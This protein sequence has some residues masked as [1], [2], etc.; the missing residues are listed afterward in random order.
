MEDGRI[1]ERG[2]HAELLTANGAYAELYN[3]QFEEGAGADA[4]RTAVEEDQPIRS[5]K[6]SRLPAIERRFSP[7]ADAWYERSSWLAL[8]APLSWLYGSVAK[9]RR[10]SY[11]TGR[12]TPWRASVPVIVVGNI[13]AGGTGK[14]P[15]VIWLAK[16]LKAMGFNPGIVSRGH[17]GSET[18]RPVSV[19]ADSSADAVGDE[20]PLLAARTGLPVVVCQDRVEAVQHLLEIAAC[21]LVIADDGLQHYALARDVEIAVVDGHRGFGNKRLLPAGP[22]RELP[23]RLAEVD[24]VVSSGRPSGVSE[25]ESL[26]K[27]KPVRFVPLDDQ[28]ATVSVED[29]AAR[30]ENV[31][32]VA[33]IGNPGRFSQTLKE[34][35]LNPLLTAYPDHHV[36]DLEEVVFEND[37]PVVCTE[38]DATKLRL[39]ENL[40]ADIF[41]LEIDSEVTEPDGSPGSEKLAALLEM[42]GIRAE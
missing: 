12:K 38:K 35:G 17:G 37:W 42:H 31:N 21:D 13:T 5:R 8:L 39:L 29:F 14:T 22:L 33:G 26:L 30:Y 16:T 2:P 1:I 10:L 40:P 18:K 6:S 9:R 15:F 27:V 24:W 3:A 19:S 23:S 25:V 36:L 4:D 11:L 20:P 41:Y 7:L 32:A 28:A 34:M